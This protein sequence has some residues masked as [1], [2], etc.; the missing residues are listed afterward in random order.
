MNKKTK[1]RIYNILKYYKSDYLYELNK[2]IIL[3]LLE[4]KDEKCLK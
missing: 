4:R 3:I 2:I 1:D